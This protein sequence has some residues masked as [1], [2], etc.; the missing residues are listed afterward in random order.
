MKVTNPPQ[1]TVDN[2]FSRMASATARIVGSHWM[3]LFACLTIVAWLATGPMFHYS[4][5]WQLIISS[6]TNIVTFLV[7]FIIQNSQN[8]DS[9]ALQLKLDEI[10]RSIEHAENDMINIERLSEQELENLSKRYE[11]I[12]NA[13]E[14]RKRG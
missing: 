5:T 7:V 4:D 12:R 3:F 1:A 2:R 8:R 6:W 11:R 10:I 13:V 9:K 14:Q